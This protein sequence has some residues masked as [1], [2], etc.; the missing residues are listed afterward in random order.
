MPL[1]PWIQLYYMSLGGSNWPEK[2]E[3]IKRWKDGRSQD[4]AAQSPFAFLVSFCSDCIST[5][6]LFI[7]GPTLW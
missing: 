2:M 4:I 5:M 6:N 7:D 3:A 1:Y